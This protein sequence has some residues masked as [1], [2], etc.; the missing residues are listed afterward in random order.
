M[1]REQTCTAS[2]ASGRFLAVPFE[3]QKQE[4]ICSYNA[5]KS[6]VTTTVR[7]GTNGANVICYLQV[8]FMIMCCTEKT[9]KL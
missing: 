4:D 9:L 7:E 5:L 1:I 6:F 8:A 3:I 2:S